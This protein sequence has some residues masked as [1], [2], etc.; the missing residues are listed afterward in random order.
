MATT[1]IDHLVLEL[2]LDPKQFNKGAASAAAEV[3]T[4]QD[5]VSYSAGEMVGA[6]QRVAAEFIGLFLVVGGVKDVV[7]LFASLNESTR[8]LGIESRNVGESAAGLRDWANLSQLAG[9][10]A[11]DAANSI[12]GLEKAI[13]NAKQGFGWDEQLTNFLRL[14]VDTGAAVGKLRDF[15][16]ILLDT[17]KA[18]ESKDKVDRYQ[19]VQKLGL[20]GGIGNAVVE[21][22]AALEAYWRKVRALPQINGADTAAAQRL[23]QSFDL[24]KDRVEAWAT[25]ILTAVEPAIEGLFN[26]ISTFLTGH[27]GD[28][29]NG[30]TSIAA[31]V[32]SD[33]PL[34]VIQALRDFAEA[35][36][37]VFRFVDAAT[38][39]ATTAKKILG[40]I[41][42]IAHLSNQRDAR[43]R[44]VLQEISAAETKYGLPAGLIAKTGN[45]PD[46]LGPGSADPLAAILAQQHAQLG[47]D[48]ADPDWYKTVQAINARVKAPAVPATVPGA[49]PNPDALKAAQGAS[50]SPLVAPQPKDAVGAPTASTVGTGSIINTVT[51]DI[52]VKTQAADAGGIAGAINRALGQKVA[53]SQVDGALA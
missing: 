53:V 27:Q 6:L 44:Q 43:D 3:K 12:Q 45:G 5:Q 21:G 47:G 34:R 41:G 51:G 23:A 17:A 28:V 8:Q 2:G 37:T 22:P 31:W 36:V 48:K 26:A 35:V 40:G 42:E 4:V 39:P 38:H 9:G 49:S 20:Q 1:I 52:F 11:E 19:W 29:S 24:L 13:F 32:A 7:G 16:A 33:G 46:Q 25:K 14:N 50:L 18:L 10:K 30:V 15:H